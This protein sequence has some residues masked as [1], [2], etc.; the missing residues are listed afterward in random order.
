MIRI[1]DKD[2]IEI[3]AKLRTE[4]QIEDWNFTSSDKDY[5]V[6]ADRFFDLTKEYLNE[7]LNMNMFFAIMVLDDIP[8]AMCAINVLNSLPQITVCE[9]FD[10]KAGEIVSVYTRK[11]YRGKGCQQKL[12]RFLLDFAQNQRF[13]DLVLTTNTEDAQ[14]IYRKLGFRYISNKYYLNIK[15]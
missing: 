13:S 9:V 2:D 14:H 3:I 1:A 4:Q 15:P 6:Y 10:A 8:V 12:L 7:N 5:S 11:Q